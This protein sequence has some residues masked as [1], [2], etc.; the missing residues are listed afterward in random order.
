[1]GTLEAGARTVGDVC[2]G[3]VPACAAHPS[4]HIHTLPLGAPAPPPTPPGPKSPGTLQADAPRRKHLHRAGT[5]QRRRAADVD[6]P[7]NAEHRGKGLQQH[8][9]RRLRGHAQVGAKGGAGE[10]G[11]RRRGAK[12]GGGGWGTRARP[13]AVGPWRVPSPAGAP[14]ALSALA[15]RKAGAAGGV[16][17]NA[18]A[19][20]SQAIGQA[21]GHRAGGGVDAVAAWPPRKILSRRPCCAPCER[22]GVHPIVTQPAPLSG[23]PASRSARQQPL[24][25]PPP[26]PPSPAP[27]SPLKPCTA[28]LRPPSIGRAMPHIQTRGGAAASMHALPAPHSTPATPPP[29]PAAARAPPRPAAAAPPVVHPAAQHSCHSR[30]AAAAPCPGTPKQNRRPAGTS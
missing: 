3:R 1:M 8:D 28:G 17:S 21:V 30:A 18:V 29:L 10:G 24:C 7:A 22:K 26:Q 9:T 25:K 15:G 6:A 16:G 20:G 27:P 5:R 14:V 12:W 19:L 23:A 13:P 11:R 4:K 2:I